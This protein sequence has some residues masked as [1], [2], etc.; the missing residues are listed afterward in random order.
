MLF[1]DP[2]DLWIM[3]ASL[4]IMVLYTL[5]LLCFSTAVMVMVAALSSWSHD[6]T[7]VYF[8]FQHGMSMPI[9]CLS[10]PRAG[11]PD[12]GVRGGGGRGGGGGRKFGGVRQQVPSPQEG[13]PIQTGTQNST[14]TYTNTASKRV[15]QR[16]IKGLTCH[17][18]E[19]HA[20]KHPCPSHTR[21]FRHSL[22]VSCY[23]HLLWCSAV[24][25]SAA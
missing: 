11:T 24:Q 16:A 22:A 15:L 23:C 6:I 2:F 25:C 12:G 18:H 14:K 7:I 8:G 17:V 19:K 21:W 9:C 10:L 1:R 5:F 13:K 3:N 20:Q 4:H